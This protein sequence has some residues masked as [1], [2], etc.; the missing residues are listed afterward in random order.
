LSAKIKSRRLRG[1]QAHS[2][3]LSL[4]VALTDDRLHIAGDHRAISGN[5]SRQLAPGILRDLCPGRSIVA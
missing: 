4:S 3:S 1:G 5:A 2:L